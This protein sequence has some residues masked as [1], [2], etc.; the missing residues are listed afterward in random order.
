MRRESALVRRRDR[1]AARTRARAEAEGFSRVFLVPRDLD[2]NPDPRYVPHERYL[3]EE[4]GH[5]VYEMVAALNKKPEPSL[6]TRFRGWLSELVPW[7]VELARGV[8]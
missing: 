1:E 2:G 5:Y 3:W 6:L 4:Q 7:R 8:N